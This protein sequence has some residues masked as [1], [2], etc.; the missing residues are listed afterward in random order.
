[1]RAYTAGLRGPTYLC[2]WH[3]EYEKGKK[4]Y[5][6][7]THPNNSLFIAGHTQLQFKSKPQNTTTTQYCF[8]CWWVRWVRWSKMIEMFHFKWQHCFRCS[9]GLDR[10]MA[11]EDQHSWLWCRSWGP[12]AFFWNHQSIPVASAP[13][14]A[15][16]D[17]YQGCTAEY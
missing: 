17:N 12:Q 16:Q 14:I 10:C 5:R 13:W 15:A 1:M 4:N 6:C 7:L 8:E 3:Q 2:A 11:K 9:L